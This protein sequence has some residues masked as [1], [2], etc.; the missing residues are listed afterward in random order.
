MAFDLVEIAKQHV[1]SGQSE[2]GK[3]NSQCWPGGSGKNYD[4]TVPLNQ[5]MV[6]VPGTNSTAVPFDF[7]LEGMAAYGL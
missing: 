7:C 3:F 4:S 6:E 2:W 5:V 1:W